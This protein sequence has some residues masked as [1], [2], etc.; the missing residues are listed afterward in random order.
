[1]TREGELPRDSW[2]LKASLAPWTRISIAGMCC[3]R[4]DGRRARL[5]VHLQPRSYNDQILLGVLGQVASGLRCKRATGV[6]SL[7]EVVPLAVELGWRP[8][9]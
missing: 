6:G 2:R 7:E 9:A 3:Y 4:P 1:V 5:A 8:D